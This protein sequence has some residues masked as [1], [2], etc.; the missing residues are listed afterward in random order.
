MKILM[1]SA[2]P[3]EA[4]DVDAWAKAN[5]TEVSTTKDPFN[6]DTVSQAKGFDGI[7]IAQHGKVADPKI[8]STLKDYG[9]KQISLRITGYDIIDFDQA[10]KNDLTI[11]NV[12]AY[13]PRSVGELT[14]THTM[15]LLRH[16]GD[17]RAREL[18]GDFSWGGLEAQ[19]IHNLTVGIIGAGKIGSAVAR[20][21]NAL[22]ATVIAQDP[23]HRP[24]LSDVLTYTDRET[25]LKTADVVTCHTPLTA[26]TQHMIN[27]QA[28][29]LMKP[30]A[31]LINCSR[32]PVV[33]TKALIQALTA[34]D[35]AGAGI[36]TIEGETGIFGEDRTGAD[37]QNPELTQLLQMPNVS[38]TPHIGFYT[39]AAVRNMV[40]IALDDA[41]R[42][43][44]GK[45]GLHEV[46]G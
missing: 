29:K 39:D 6:L 33:D 36:D 17:T 34:Q 16:I 4:A 44:Q 41:L 5:N 15:F 8:Y 42:I 32:G 19:E 37:Y 18:K 35:I 14:L 21:F 13:S 23:I 24:E 11:T 30:T 3:D 31:L 38:V 2:R 40:D 46:K 26:E 25:L 28:L 7:V 9:M 27:A 43:L 1:Y 10:A 22:G 12:P 45:P 20:L